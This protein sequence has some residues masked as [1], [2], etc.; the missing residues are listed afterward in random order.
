MPLMFRG[1]RRP[2]PPPSSLAAGLAL[3]VAALAAPAAL[4]QGTGPDPLREALERLATRA[5]EPLLDRAGASAAPDPDAAFPEGVPFLIRFEGDLRGLE[6]GA[7]VT[8]LGRRVGTVRAVALDYDPEGGVFVAPVLIDL[9]PA[10]VSVA[11][12][13]PTTPEATEEMVD[14]LVARGLRARVAPAGLMDRTPR[15]ELAIVE[16]LP[17]RALLRDGPAAEIPAAPDPEAALR[18]A[19]AD[20]LERVQALPLE[21]FVAEGRETLA[22]AR[23]LITGPEIRGALAEIGTAT[24]A[25]ALTVAGLEARLDPAFEELTGA[26][27]EARAAAARAG[28]TAASLDR[29]VGA[30]APIWTDVDQ[31]MRELTASARAMRQFA[32]YLERHP[33]A[34]IT[35]KSQ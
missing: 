5:A 31:L 18:A 6:A 20:L 8:I 7:P 28:A 14:L 33:E 4:A 10:R 34:L 23:A 3:T 26:A 30:R 9:A 29:T 13:Q 35:G 21:A 1:N 27:R 25:F 12:R 15:V 22:E 19:L 24:E 11:G 2:A 16:G 17:A 32:E